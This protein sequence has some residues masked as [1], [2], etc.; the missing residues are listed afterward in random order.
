MRRFELMDGTSQ[1]FWEITLEGSAFT[2]HF[3]RIGAKGQTQTKTFSSPEAAR[4]ASEKLIAEKLGK[5]YSETTGG[6]APTHEPAKKKASYKRETDGSELVERLDG[7][8]K[9]H[10]P[11]FARG[12]AR[13]ATAAEVGM[14]EKHAGASL[15]A[16]FKAFLMWRGE[17]RGRLYKNYSTMSVKEIIGERTGLNQLSD[18]GELDSPGWWHQD[19]VPFLGNGGGDFL[20]L[21]LGGA[22]KGVPGQVLEYWHGD[23]D[24]TILYPS[25]D[26]WLSVFVETLEAGL[27][28]GDDSGFFGANEEGFEAARKRAYPGYP[29]DHSADEEKPPTQP[30]RAAPEIVGQMTEEAARRLLA[31]WT[32][33]A[34]EPREV[35]P[36]HAGGFHFMWR[37]GEIVFDP[38]R[39]ILVLGHDFGPATEEK[40]QDD[41]W[42]ELLDKERARVSADYPHGRIEVRQLRF[43]A[44]VDRDPRLAYVLVR[45]FG[46]PAITDDSFWQEWL[47]FSQYLRYDWNLKFSWA[48][49]AEHKKRGDPA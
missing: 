21:D 1:K 14:L 25:F 45:E 30:R 4:T 18:D 20:C 22:F 2:V 6:P 47:E 3:G 26:A 44:E 36:A 24:R 29:K 49:Q 38:Q 9:E 23:D 13:G 46:D 19:W 17:G 28:D 48:V 42:R 15:P 5:G 8:I 10:R 35:D 40:Y 34:Y 37:S 39:K 11:R 7:W 12:L 41:V 32:S 43:R 31:V 16:S 33:N 27:W